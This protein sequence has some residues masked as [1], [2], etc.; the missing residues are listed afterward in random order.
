MSILLKLHLENINLPI[1]YTNTDCPSRSI[2]PYQTH[3]NPRCEYLI[4]PLVRP[5]MLSREK[6]PRVHAQYRG[7]AW[8]DRA[9]P[10]S[11]ILGIP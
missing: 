7:I 5:H 2:Y 9:V 11:S 8:N 10:R 6:S 4:N 1:E 3:E